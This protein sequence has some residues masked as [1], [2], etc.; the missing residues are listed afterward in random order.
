MRESDDRFLARDAPG[1]GEAAAGDHL[2]TGYNLWLAGH[3]LERG[4]APWID[5]YSFQPE[6][7]PVAN[8]Q[9]WLFG[10]PYWPLVAALG[11]VLA[12]NVFIV[13]S[14]LLAGGLACAWLRQLGLPGTAALAGGLVFA[15]APYRVGQSTGHL[16]G[17]VSALIP[18]ALLAFERSTSVAGAGRTRAWQALGGAALAAIPL[19]GQV[20]LALGA[21]P[22]FLAYALVRTRERAP[23]VAAGLGV[24]AAAAA[25]LLVREVAI[26]GSI[27]SGGRSLASVGRYSADWQDFVTRDVRGGIEQFVFLGWVTPLVALAGLIVLGQG[28]RRGLAAVL[29][30]AAVI[31][32]VLAL[33]TNLPTYELLWNALPPFRFPRVPERLM[34]IACLALAALVAFA[35]ARIRPPI[36][37]LLIMATLVLDVRVPVYAAV[38]A[39]EENRAYAALRAA[40][41]GRL[42]ELPVFRPDLHFGSAYLY[43]SMQAPRERPGGYS[44]LAPRP[45]DRLA[46]RL[47]P[48]SC[49]AAPTSLRDLDVRYV[50]VHRALYRQS[51]FFAP[52]CAARAERALERQGFRLL[53]RDE[54]IALLRR[55]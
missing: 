51:G 27:S 23:L 32:I 8:L 50:A 35:M 2:Q 26:A 25:G 53:A 3:Q 10:L 31:P 34:P 42:L 30:L 12:W 41:P 11:S 43:Y 49:G 46:R 7:E 44:T 4:A 20:H 5:P 14:Y 16:L 33:G 1:Y 17:P 21:I 40:P 48:V 9:G 19:S 15:L 55:G 6:A 22:F 28:R 38:A 29:G 36:A 24:L 13:F 37:A 52:N 54:Q 39:D 45:A 18:L 47:R